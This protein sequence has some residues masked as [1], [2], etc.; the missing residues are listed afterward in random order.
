MGKQI[1][2]EEALQQLEA[3]V[4]KLEKPDLPLEESIRLFEEGM[5]LSEV[6][7]TKLDSAQQR[8]EILQKQASGELKP[9]PFEGASEDE[10]EQEDKETPF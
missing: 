9:T 2:F 5:K 6:C 1:T 7:S 10:P 4:K 8:V 3:V